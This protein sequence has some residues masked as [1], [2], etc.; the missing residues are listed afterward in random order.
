MPTSVPAGRILNFTVQ[1]MQ[2]RPSRN[3]HQ[4]VIVCIP[5]C[6]SSIFLQV[7]QMA[8]EGYLQAKYPT[9]TSVIYIPDSFSTAVKELKPNN[10]DRFFYYHIILNKH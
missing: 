10:V 3:G 7:D 2:S 5:G 8:T 1:K 9:A 6:V 4:N